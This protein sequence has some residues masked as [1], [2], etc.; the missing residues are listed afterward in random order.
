[1]GGDCRPNKGREPIAPD[2]TNF[3]GFISPTNMPG[4]ATNGFTLPT[5]PRGLRCS[6]GLITD[7][8]SQIMNAPSVARNL[9]EPYDRSE[10]KA[11]QIDSAGLGGGGG[12]GGGGSSA[13]QIGFAPTITAI[14]TQSGNTANVIPLGTI[15]GNMTGN[16]FSSANDI[17]S[18]TVCPQDSWVSNMWLKI[19]DHVTQVAYA[20]TGTNYC[21]GIATNGVVVPFSVLSVYFKSDGSTTLKP[22][23]APNPYSSRLELL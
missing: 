12:G 6:M 10:R 7:I 15:S 13:L 5:S 16:P 8:A 23:A 1:M 21:A 20:G 4:V 17:F 3:T 2:A 14:M 19:S 9:H 11:L 18:Q 22:I